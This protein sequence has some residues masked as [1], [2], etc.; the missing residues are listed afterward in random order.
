M[1]IEMHTNARLRGART[2]L[3]STTLRSASMANTPGV[4]KNYETATHSVLT[5]ARAWEV[6]GLHTS[7][8]R[9]T[10]C[11]HQAK[12]GS[13]SSHERRGATRAA[14]AA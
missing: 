12:K 11:A 9:E 2:I 7:A 10:L 8:V 14:V 1:H 5:G 13:E 3:P 6:R 4:G